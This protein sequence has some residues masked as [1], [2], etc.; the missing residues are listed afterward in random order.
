MEPFNLNLGSYTISQLGY[1]YKDIEKQAT[2]LESYFGIQK[3]VFYENKSDS[4]KYRGEKTK[5]W[6]KIGLSRIFN[7]QIELIQLIDGN[8]IYKELIESGKEGFHHFG[9]LVDDISSIRAKFLKEGYEIVHEGGTSLY[10]VI[11][12][13]T[14]KELGVFLEFQES[15]KK[16]KK[17]RRKSYK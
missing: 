4:Y 15:I 17:L 1:I 10:N 13:D 5:F 16:T 11:Y 3:F 6:V 7:F 9:I 12:F 14:I 8:C 2:L